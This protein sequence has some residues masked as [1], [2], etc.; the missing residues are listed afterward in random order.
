MKRF[1]F[2][3]LV[4]VMLTI[5]PSSLSAKPNDARKNTRRAWNVE[6]Q[7][8]KTDYLAKKL[9]LTAEQ[10]ERFSA[11]YSK[12]EGELSSVSN[13][14]RKIIDEVKAKGKAA[15][16]A[17]YRKA[18]AASF[19]LKGKE[20]AIEKK[21]F[22]QYEKILTPAQLFSLKDAEM[23]FTKE[24]MKKHSSIRKNARKQKKLQ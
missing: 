22:T 6:M 11:L 16:D 19:E 5:V 14:T 4:L 7:T 17:D 3:Y 13:D 23:Q 1:Y 20:A 24:L 18:A 15:T 10:K 12:M 2:I 21:Y 9:D 8:V